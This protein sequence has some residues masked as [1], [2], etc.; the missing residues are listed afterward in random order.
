ML[1]TSCTNLAST[2][3]LRTY[4]VRSE[5][6]SDIT[7]V[8]AALATCASQPSFA[9][10]S[11]GTGHKKEEYVGAGIGRNNPVRDIITEAHLLFGGNSTVASLLSLGSGYF[12]AV[13]LPEF[14]TFN[15]LLA[16]HTESIL[17]AQRRADEVQ[18]Q[19]GHLGI[20]F[21]LSVDI[22]PSQLELM[23]DLSQLVAQTKIHLAK[24]YVSNMLDACIKSM[25][26][27]IGSFTL[28]QLSK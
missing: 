2:V 23:H 11:F 6:P 1:V 12:G 26:A 10:V 9:P 16:A 24:S 5:P 21:R 4:P 27:G 13:S 14:S 3:R 17:D 7:I 18:D 8:A 20:Y 28:D 25:D 22:Q 19:I 15:T